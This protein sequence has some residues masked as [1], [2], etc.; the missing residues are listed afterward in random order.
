LKKKPHLQQALDILWSSNDWKRDYSGVNIVMHS[1]QKLYG[2][3]STTRVSNITIAAG[4]SNVVLQDL[5]PV[6]STITPKAGGVI[7][8]CTLK[9][10]KY[11][12]LVATNAID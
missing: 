3:P 10:I 6:G 5:Y 4:S 2:N 8:N 11:A 1:N 12:T 9:S 7:S